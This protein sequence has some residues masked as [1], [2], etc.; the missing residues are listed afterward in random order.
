MSLLKKYFIPHKENDYH[1]HLFRSAGL[2]GMLVI[3]VAVFVFVIGGSLVIIRTDFTALVLPRV[4]V[5]YANQDRQPLNLKT[6]AISPVLEKAAQ[7]KADDMASRGYFAHKSPEGHTPWYF[8]DQVGYDFSYAGENLAVNFTDSVDVNSAWMVSPGHRQN[9]V[10]GNFTEIGIATAEGLY[11]GRKTVFVVQL[12]GRPAVSETLNNVTKIKSSESPKIT[13]DSS[14]SV[15]G[16]S[17][18]N[19][20]YI[21]VE[22]KSAPESSTTQ[23]IRYSNFFEK[24][25]S[26]P[27]KTLTVVY[28]VFS[29]FIL[30]GLMFMIVIGVRKQYKIYVVLALALIALMI[31][32][33][34]GFQSFLIIPLIIV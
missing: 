7:M 13:T 17:G 34:Y 21:T 32:L 14:R 28:F 10:N 26:S 23:N 27:K 24:M 8:F 3:I 22:K 2:F 29:I 6:L 4:L 16:A 19:N 31:A 18:E 9:I 5:D 33:L 30:T 15:L 20:L 25:F 12:F 11:D 1:P